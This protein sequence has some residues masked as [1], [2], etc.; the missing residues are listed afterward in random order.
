M[1]MGGIYDDRYF[2]KIV[3]G[4]IVLGIII[5]ALV[6]FI[7]RGISFSRKFKTI[8][9]G[10]AYDQVISI[11]GQPDK[12][13]TTE[14]ITTCVWEIAVVRSYTIT[15]VIVFKNGKVFSITDI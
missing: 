9:Q 5:A 3:L 8:K 10:M 1:D 13:D 6:G 7:V 2:P 15:K 12:S 4:I 14:D 11:I